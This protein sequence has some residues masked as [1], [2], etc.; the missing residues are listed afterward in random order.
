MSEE[1]VKV[2]VLEQKFAD[3][4]NIVNKLDDAIQKL[5][6]VNTNVIKMLAVHDEK[7]EYG[8]RTDDLILKM[9]DNFKEETQKEYKKTSDRIDDLEGQVGEISKIRWMTVGIGVVLTVL[10]GLFANLASGWLT[11]NGMEDPHRIGQTR[12][13]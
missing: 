12:I 5:S 4:A 2:A 9:I 11:P 13:K 10:V 6:E 7:I 3:F 1:V 8:Q